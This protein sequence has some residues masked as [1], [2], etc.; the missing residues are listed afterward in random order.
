MNILSSLIKQYEPLFYQ[1]YGSAILPGQRKALRVMKQC[2]TQQAYKMLAVCSEKTCEEHE[3][4]PHSCG[5]RHCPHCQHHEGGQW[6]ENQL[7]KQVPAE[8]YL[9]TFTLPRRVITKSCV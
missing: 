3:Y 1:K 6:I 9:I 7:K 2:R 8:Y 4:I 5:H